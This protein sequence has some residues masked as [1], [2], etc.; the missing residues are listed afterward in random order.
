[1]SSS[2]G[3]KNLDWG[4][5][6]HAY[7][8]ETP[9]PSYAVLANRFGVGLGT[10]SKRAREEGWVAAREETQDRL[11]AKVAEQV[12]SSVVERYQAASDRIFAQAESMLD[13]TEAWGREI[14]AHGGNRRDAKKWAETLVVI[15]SLLGLSMEK[16]S[17]KGDAKIDALRKGFETLAKS[18]R[19]KKGM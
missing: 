12:E 18:W 5:I 11:H 3:P 17:G 1:M 9:R 19:E 7:V 10:L 2:T 16:A 13:T 14:S 4:A 6:K 15:F 8:Y